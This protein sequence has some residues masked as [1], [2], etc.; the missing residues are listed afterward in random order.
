MSIRIAGIT[1]K[2]GN[3]I[4]IVDTGTT[5]ILVPSGVVYQLIRKIPGYTYDYDM[6]LY[7]TTSTNLASLPCKTNSFKYYHDI[8]LYVFSSIFESA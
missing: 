5:F 4:G 1:Y 3:F 2:R 6:G 8:V 7:Y